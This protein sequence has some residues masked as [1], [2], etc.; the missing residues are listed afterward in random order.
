MRGSCDD[1]LKTN[2]ELWRGIYFAFALD[3][4]V[5]LLL[6]LVNVIIGPVPR[7][8]FGDEGFDHLSYADDI[9]NLL[10]VAGQTEEEIEG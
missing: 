5:H 3:E 7:G 9:E 2:V 1:E 10:V 8:P 4:I 6:Q